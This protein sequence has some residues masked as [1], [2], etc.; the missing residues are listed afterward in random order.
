MKLNIKYHW[1]L[2]LNGVWFHGNISI[3]FSDSWTRRHSASTV[4]L[5]RFKHY[6]TSSLTSR[7]NKLAR[8]STS[9]LGKSKICDNSLGRFQTL[10]TYIVIAWKKT[11]QVQTLQLIL[12]APSAT[13]KTFY[14]VV[15]TA[16]LVFKHPSCS[17]EV[18]GHRSLPGVNVVDFYFLR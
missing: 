8:L 1:I 14:N 17:A 10:L 11:C 6:K 9:F 16:R 7:Q 5:V 18:L 15:F 2:F 12:S 13:K 3:Y 4:W